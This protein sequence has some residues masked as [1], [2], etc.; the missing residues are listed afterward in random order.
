MPPH[1]IKLL[2]LNKGRGFLNVESN[3]DS[4]TI[5]I[6]DIIVD[7]DFFGGVTAIDV[8]K[9][10]MALK[11]DVIHLRV[12]SPGGDVFAARSI[13]Q[14]IKE[15]PSKIVAHVDGIAASAA[16]FPVIAAD[17]SFI[18]EGGMFMIH[19]SWT[20]AAGNANDFLDIADLLDKTDR[21]ILSSYA[22]KTGLSEEIIKAMMDKET[23]FLGKEAVEMGFID[24]MADE[25]PKNKIKWDLSAYGNA[26]KQENNQSI[27]S[28]LYRKLEA[29]Q[30]IAL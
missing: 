20:I 27:Y 11:Q 12:N 19:N 4:A 24:G 23:Y 17:E 1:L 5:F 13:A 28:G 8:V 10:L 29:R 7:D 2:S 25:S 14:A 3:N 6:Y 9:Q 30:R 18:S 26:P 15:H 21:S 16:T 22:A